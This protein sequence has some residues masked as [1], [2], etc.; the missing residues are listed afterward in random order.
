M[1]ELQLTPPKVV[2]DPRTQRE[3]FPGMTTDE[4]LR[5]LELRTFA[6]AHRYRLSQPC[7][8]SADGVLVISM[9]DGPDGAEDATLPGD[10]YP[11][12]WITPDGLIASASVNQPVYFTSL[13]SLLEVFT[14]NEGTT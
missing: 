13:E 9:H 7:R 14:P 1:A 11:H 5:Y 4:H 3:F 8:N 12:F 6:E 2:T 10:V